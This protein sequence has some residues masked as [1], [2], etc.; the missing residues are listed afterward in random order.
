MSRADWADGADW[1]DWAD[2]AD[3]ADWADRADGGRFAGADMGATI[4]AGGRPSP[5]SPGPDPWA[6]RPVTAPDA[7]RLPRLLAAAGREGLDAHLARLGPLSTGGKRRPGATDAALVDIVTE[8]GLLGRG[9]AAFPTGRKL[10]AVAEAARAIGRPPLVVV[11]AMVFISPT[12][13]A[14]GDVTALHSLID[15]RGTSHGP[16]APLA[17]LM[18]QIPPE[19][20]F[21]A[22]YSGGPIHLPF[23]ENSNLGNLNH[24]L[25]SL[26]NGTV[27]FDLRAGLNGVAEGVCTSD[28][29]A[30]DV[31][32]ALK[33]LIGF[34][35]LSV[36]KNQPELAQVYDG[37][38]VTQEGHRVKLYIDVPESMVD[39]FIGMWTGRAR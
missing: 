37:L 2:G 25:G 24:L 20:L 26:Q 17:A 31:E 30:Q 1:A 22:A 27:Y 19:A 33:A 28:A 3:G 14:L 6:H 29:A 34:G 18:K 5:I 4:A 35:R 21:W 8:S 39:K 9:G 7:T 23:D 36:P 16:P 38:R 11:N 12:T 32:G 13:A 15:Q 10:R